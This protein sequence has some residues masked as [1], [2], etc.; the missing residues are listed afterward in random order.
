MKA[1]ENQK[2]RKA[3]IWHLIGCYKTTSGYT[4]IEVLIALSLSS[5]GFIGGLMLYRSGH[6]VL[7]ISRATAEI[8]QGSRKALETMIQ[9]L[10]ETTIDSVDVS[11]PQAISF[12][13]AWNSG[14]FA[15]NIDWTPDW[16]QA[17][18]YFLDTSTNTLC[19]YVAPKDDWSTGF[20]TASA[21]SATN[22]ERLVPDVTR[23]EFAWVGNLL[24]IT[25]ETSKNVQTADLGNVSEALTT[26]VAMQN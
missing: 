25:I 21:F 11:V 1:Q 4:L 20:N 16:K 14:T 24:R 5:I 18:V 19:R 15:S 23:L 9:E 13:S 26:Q 7:N 6:R 12:A 3:R 17:V 10:Q 8:E 22:I 2:T